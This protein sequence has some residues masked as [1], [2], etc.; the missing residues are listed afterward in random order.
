MD[1]AVV[2]PFDWDKLVEVPAMDT[3]F[4][5]WDRLRF[6]GKFIVNCIDVNTQNLR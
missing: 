1:S 4:G 3:P 6:N 5:C 2:A